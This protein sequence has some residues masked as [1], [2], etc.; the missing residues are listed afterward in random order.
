M[1][2]FL[3]SLKKERETKKRNSGQWRILDFPGVGVNPK[4]GVA[5]LLFWPIFPQKLHENEKISLDR[6]GAEGS[7][8]ASPSHSHFDLSMVD[9]SCIFSVTE[10]VK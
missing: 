7:V 1:S 10:D 2:W 5:N 9:V 4:G 6:G 8:G 3:Y